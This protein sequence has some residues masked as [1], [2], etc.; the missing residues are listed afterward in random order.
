MRAV[1]ITSPLKIDGKLDEEVYRTIPSISDFIQQEPNEGAPATEKTEVW[2]F[3][4]DEN[5]YVMARCWDSHPER[6]I[7]TEMRR[8]GSRIPRNEDL[9]FGLDTFFDHRNGYNFEQTPIGGMMDAQISND[10]AAIDTN[11]NGVL[12]HRA[13]RFEQGWAVEMRIPF[14]TL[15]YRAGP[16]QLWAL[17]VRR[18]VREIVPRVDVGTVRRVRFRHRSRN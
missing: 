13:D 15:R 9:A 16:N 1:R 14:K 3:F 2:L 18:M 7:A 12:E 6:M 4:D 11:W 17:Q 8:D 5:F 10:G